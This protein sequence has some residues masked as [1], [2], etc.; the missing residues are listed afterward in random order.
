[1]F[2]NP[3]VLK[4]HK[5]WQDFWNDNRQQGS[6]EMSMSLNTIDDSEFEDEY[7]SYNTEIPAS[8]LENLEE[9]R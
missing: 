7:D 5:Y 3:R 1:M 4:W 8:Y 9:L 6:A 2:A